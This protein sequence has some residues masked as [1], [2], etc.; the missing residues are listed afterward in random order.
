MSGSR[1]Y[2]I[3][4]APSNRFYLFMMSRTGSSNFSFH[5]SLDGLRYLIIQ[6]IKRLETYSLPVH[7][8]F[9]YFTLENLYVIAEF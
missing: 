5:V 9:D 2:R 8:K 1:V 7:N 3:S 4:P 6:S